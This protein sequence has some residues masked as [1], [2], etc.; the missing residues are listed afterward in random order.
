MGVLIFEDDD[1]DLLHEIINKLQ[2]CFHH[3]YAP[4]GQFSVQGLF[5][6][7]KQ[8]KNVRIIVDRN[9]ISP[10][11][12]IATK[13]RMKDTYRMQKVALFVTWSKYIRAQL[14]SGLGLYENDTSGLCTV[15]GE[16]NRLQFLHGVDVI[17]AQLWKMLAF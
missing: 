10:I 11:C 16:E 4:S 17:P 12:E 14:L 6:L 13:G 9:I 1:L 8:E 3:T 15:S 2:I 7:Q 5:E